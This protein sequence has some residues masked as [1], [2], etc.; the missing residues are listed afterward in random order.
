VWCGGFEKTF[1]VFKTWKV[2]S[3]SCG[4]IAAM[5]TAAFFDVDGTLYTANMWRGLVQ[6]V[7][8]NGRRA[9]TRAYFY[10]LMPLY[11]LRKLRLVSEETF[12][13]PWV[14]KLGW[15]I[16]GWSTAQGDAAFRWVANEY[17]RPSA[18]A[19]IIARLR[20]HVAQGHAVFLVSAMLKPTLRAIGEPLGV[21]DV[22]G[23]EIEIKDG[24]FTGAIASRV[25]M[26]AAKGEMT[27]EFLR[28]RGSEI[29]FAASYAYA[30]SFS[31]LSLFELVGHPIAVYPDAELEAHARAKNWEIV[32]KANL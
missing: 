2:F 21:T 30:D 13:K 26:G 28:A 17:I 31:D 14:A 23:T 5:K 1:Q 27:R 10:G 6:Y 32:G 9:R 4:I 22:I 29:D 24:C 16:Q 12:R 25:C 20:D 8:Q 19:D 15:L 11:F 18:R 3:K 7:A